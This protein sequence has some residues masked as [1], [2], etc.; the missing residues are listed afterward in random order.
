MISSL[1]LWQ[2]STSHYCRKVRLTLGYKNINY[3]IQNLTPGLH[4]LQLK[5]KTGLTT[6][7]V[8]EVKE[9]DHITWIAESTEIIKFLEKHFPAPSL[10]LPNPQDQ[11][12]S[13]LLEDWLDESIGTATRFIYYDFRSGEGKSLNSSFSSQLLISIVRH[14]YG[15]TPESLTLAKTRL[16]LALEILSAK[17]QNNIYLVGGK[18]SVA[19]ITAAS[20]LSPL[21]IIPEYQHNYPLLFERIN[22]IHDLC[23]EPIYSIN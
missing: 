5:P 9:D 11:Q 14:Q 21:T 1:K 17:W 19:D 10:L 4:I 6:V 13:L 16:N 8:L 3:Q 12:E 2:F 22:H 20:L 23:K 18:F 7:P 15:I